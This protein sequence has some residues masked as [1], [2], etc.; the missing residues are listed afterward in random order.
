MTHSNIVNYSF[1]QNIGAVNLNAC[2]KEWRENIVAHK[3]KSWQH[4]RRQNALKQ[5]YSTHEVIIYQLTSTFVIKFHSFVSLVLIMISCQTETF[6]NEKRGSDLSEC[7]YSTWPVS[8]QIHIKTY[9]NYRTCNSHPLINR[10]NVHYFSLAHL[11]NI[12]F[13]Q[14][15]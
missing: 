3:N 4:S 2:E 10:M 9:N 6:M 15:R 14:W 12:L 13:Q 1:E 7:I 11:Q 8:S 5:I